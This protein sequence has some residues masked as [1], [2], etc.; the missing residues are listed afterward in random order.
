M[1]KIN[2]WKNASKQMGN[3]RNLRC[4]GTILD[5]IG[6]RPSC[7]YW[8]SGPFNRDSFRMLRN[9]FFYKFAVVYEIPGSLL[10]LDCTL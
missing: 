7:C 4:A 5:V 6:F 9:S 1:Y 2:T 10:V 3:N 8:Q